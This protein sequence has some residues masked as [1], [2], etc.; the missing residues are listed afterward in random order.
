M[1]EETLKETANTE[2]ADTLTPVSNVDVS[3][4]DVLKGKVRR[5]KKKGKGKGDGPRHPLTGLNN[6]HV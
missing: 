4:N 2:N 6:I 1:K 5:R 3:I